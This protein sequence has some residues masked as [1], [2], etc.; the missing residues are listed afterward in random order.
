MERKLYEPTEAEAAWWSKPESKAEARLAA[1]PSDA[2]I[3]AALKA[4]KSR[5][6]W[7]LRKRDIV[8]QAIR[9]SS[10][11]QRGLKQG[12][13]DAAQGCE[14]SEERAEKP[15]NSGYYEGYTMFHSN[16]RGW[17]PAQR[18]EFMAKYGPQES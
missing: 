3:K 5:K 10:E 1:I 4:E 17:Q 9:T 18:A 14:Y 7:G 6:P 13:V 15:Y 11:Y 8:L 16:V 12:Y 2:E